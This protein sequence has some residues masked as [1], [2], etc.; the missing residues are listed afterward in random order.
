MKI[1]VVED[2]ANIASLVCGQLL[3]AGYTAHRAESLSDARDAIGKSD[4]PLVLI[5]RRL[6]DG[7]GLDLVADFKARQPGAR[8]I[9]L[10]AL[11]AKGEKIEG[12]DA[13]ADD[14]LTKPFEPDELMARIRACLRRPA[15][16]RPPP[17]TCGALS[18]DFSTRTALVRERLLL[19]PGL[20][21]TLLE[22]LIRNLRRTTSRRELMKEVYGGLYSASQSNTLDSLVSRLRRHLNEGNAG[23][24][25]HPVRGVGYILTESDR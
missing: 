22:T 13:G 24:S 1:L 8:V 18:Y 21:L 14:Y 11:D 15:G 4:F 5:D 17:V 3:A 23:V 19:L 12:L 9:M 7:D 16:E 6:P 10:T 2:D 20:E 25:I